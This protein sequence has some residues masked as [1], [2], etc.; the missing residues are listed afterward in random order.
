MASEKAMFPDGLFLL[1]LIFVAVVL[2][3]IGYEISKKE[4]NTPEVIQIGALSFYL[5]GASCLVASLIL[6]CALAIKVIFR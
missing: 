4:T 2:C 5:C 6:C 1:L 3:L